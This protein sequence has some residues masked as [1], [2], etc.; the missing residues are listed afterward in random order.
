MVDYLTTLGAA[1]TKK[2]REI[3]VD[4]ASRAEKRFGKPRIVNIGVEYGASLHCLRFGSPRADLYGIDLDCS[5]L[6]GD[7]RAFLI[8]G[9][10]SNFMI[11]ERIPT[12]FH[13]LFIDGDHSYSGVLSDGRLWTPDVEVGGFVICHDYVN[14][15]TM[16]ILRNGIKDV[17]PATDKWI[18]ESAYTWEK[19][20]SEDSLLVLERKA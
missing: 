17:R 7:P 14:I 9:N 1:M 4:V 5:K 3:L 15:Q 18:E 8:T 2:E 19:L 20:P 6:I 16:E 13:V 12:P 11:K 10:S